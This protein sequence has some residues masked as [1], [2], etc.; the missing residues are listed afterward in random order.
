M[1]PWPEPL[2][3]IQSGESANT[4]DCNFLNTQLSLMLRQRPRGD[5]A[6]PL[7]RK[8]RGWRPLPG[9]GEGRPTLVQPLGSV[10]QPGRSTVIVP[11]TPS[12]AD[13]PLEAVNW[14]SPWNVGW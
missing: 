8:C 10:I 5:G 13:R 14:H 9:D 4:N 1:V 7:L 12:R 6:P 11:I 3:R 2:T